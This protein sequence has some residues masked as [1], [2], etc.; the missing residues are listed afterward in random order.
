MVQAGAP[1]GAVNDDVREI[2]ND[3]L[4]RLTARFAEQ[5]QHPKGLNDMTLVHLRDTKESID[6]FLARQEIYLNR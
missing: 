1:S 5:I 4:R 2:C 6:K 3:S